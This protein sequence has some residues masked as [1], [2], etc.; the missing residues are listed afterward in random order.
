[1]RR[2]A[3]QYVQQQVADAVAMGAENLVDPTQFTYHG[4]GAYLAPQVLTEMQRGLTRVG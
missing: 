3:A 4:E 1:M 2:S